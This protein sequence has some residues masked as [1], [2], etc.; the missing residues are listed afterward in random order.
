[1][2]RS[3]LRDVLV[4]LFVLAGLA[5]MAYLSI[6]VGGFTWHGQGGLKLTASFQETGGL[7]VHAPVVVAGLRVGEVTAI[8]LDFD[9]FNAIVSIDVDP[10][11]KLS[12]DTF[13]NVITAGMLGDHLI[14]LRPGGD[15]RILKSG[16]RISRHNNAVIIEDIIGQVVYGLTKSDSSSTKPAKNEESP[17]KLP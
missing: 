8:D 14:E 16:D 12:S 13:A 7:S 17:P 5:A 3:P 2:D 1:M 4:G 15:D 6:S 10:R 11:L 9:H